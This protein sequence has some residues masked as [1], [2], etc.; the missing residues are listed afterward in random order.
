MEHENSTTIISAI[1]FSSYATDIFIILGSIAT[2]SLVMF[3]FLQVR[4]MRRTNRLAYEPFIVPRF[5]VH[6]GRRILIFA[7]IGSGSAHDV[8]INLLDANN[9]QEIGRF[10]RLAL[11]KGEER[12][13]QVAF[14]QFPRIRTQ[15]TYRNIINEEKTI[16][17]I[18]DINE[19][20]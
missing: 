18:A 3:L 14:D 10:S 6:G 7:N 5:R 4:E 9:D 2:A 17:T 16:D 8:R 15:G 1:D 12:D 19:L 11:A 13:S 20:V